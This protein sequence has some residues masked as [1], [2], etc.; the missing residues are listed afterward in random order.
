MNSAY[1]KTIQKKYN[2]DL[3]FIYGEKEINSF[4]SK[5]YNK[6]N[7]GTYLN[8]SNNKK[9]C[10]FEMEKTQDDHYNLSHIG[11]LILAMSKRIMNEVMCL[12]EDNSIELFYQDTD[13]MHL[14]DKDIEKLQKIFKDKYNREL[15]GKDLGQFHSDFKSKKIPKGL[16]IYSKKL[17]ALG[18]KCY[19][20]VL[21]AIDE[22]GKVY[23][24]YHI[25]LKGV[26]SQ[27][28]EYTAK[29]RNQSIEQLYMDL[30]NENKIEFD[31]TCGNKKAC[32]KFFKNY[33]VI[34]QINFTREIQF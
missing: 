5:N 33:E 13:S 22:K 29:K 9:A 12:A 18:K 14:Y 16:D 7:V 10:R 20:D 34:T 1:G 27:S 17:I 11:S 23:N 6:I 2:N 19:L 3:K 24:D 21:E 28:I 30:Y 31:L 26:S 8:T 4:I 15:I 32:F 25:R